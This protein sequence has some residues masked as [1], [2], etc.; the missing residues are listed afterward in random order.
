MNDKKPLIV[1][2]GLF[3]SMSN[4]IIPGTGG[5]SFGLA[6]MVYEPFILMLET[7]GYRRDQNL[8]IC[9]YDW[10]QHIEHSAQHY[11]AKTIRYAKQQTGS[12]EVNIVSHSMGGLVSRAYVQGPT[13]Q[14]D[15]DQL[16]ILCTPNA[17]SAP[18]YS[19]WTEGELSVNIN[20]KFNFVH[21]YM[22]FYI[23]YLQ[24]RYSTSKTEA[25]HQHFHGLQD[26]LPS[27]YYGNYL[28]N[29]ANGNRR[30]VEYSKMRTKNPFLDQLNNNRGIIQNRGIP[31]TIIAGTEEET[32]NYLEVDAP[33]SQC[34]DGRVAGA[35]FTNLGDGD[36]TQHSVFLLEGD[37]YTI[38]GTHVEVLYKSENILRS[39]L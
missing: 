22:R 27:S 18:N 35:A 32:I 30:F 29:N 28:I 1:V 14:N 33:T 9:F 20:G 13:Y 38:K 3:G 16:I 37:H 21:F 10:S 24:R 31:V 23:D 6:G 4:K 2:P 39:K 8:F 12:D 34:P 7:M 26:I 25:I 5:W 36:A 19:Y 17:G 15:V 11:L